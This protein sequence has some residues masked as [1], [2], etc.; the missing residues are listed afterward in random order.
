M[1]KILKSVINKI[2]TIDFDL[3]KTYKLQRKF[4]DIVRFNYLKV[5]DKKIDTTIKNENYN[6]PIRIFFPKSESKKLIIYFHGGGWVVG[7]ISSYNK[8]CARLAKETNTIV[9]S[10]DYRLAPEYRFPIGLED[11]YKVVEHFTNK[12]NLLDIDKNN[13]ILMGDSAG[14][15]L[16]AAISL[17][18][19]DRKVFMPNKQ[20]LLYPATY[21]NHSKSSPFKSVHENGE[22]WLLTSKRIEEYM[23]LYVKNKEDLNNYYVAPLLC[24]NLENQPETLIITAE[25]DPLRDEGEAYGLKLKEF[26]NEVQIHCIL[27]TIHGFFSTSI[28][29]EPLNESYKYIKRFIGCD[30]FND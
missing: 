18:C 6:I 21:N 11:C 25:L 5:L 4:H 26:G 15:N 9:V 3:D 7:N 19:R 22:K 27:D 29:V 12:N 14:G 2:S 24:K 10:V 1:Q 23:N 16:V 20:I 30:E 17:L 8:T 28:L 13:I